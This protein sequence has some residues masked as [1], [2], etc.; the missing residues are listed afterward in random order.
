M[1]VVQNRD[2][3]CGERLN[4]AALEC[5]VSGMF[6][7][8]DVVNRPYL[9]AS[10]AMALAFGCS[11]VVP[12]DQV[13]LASSAQH[14]QRQSTDFLVTRLSRRLSS[15]ILLPL[16]CSLE[17]PTNNCSLCFSSPSSPSAT[18]SRI[19]ERPMKIE[20]IVDPARPLSLASRVAPA[21]A[22]PAVN[23]TQAPRLVSCV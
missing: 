6:G 2:W 18:T 4:R 22:A 15:Q 5:T 9:T 19:T 12:L 11:L 23:G 13:E 3:Y 21:A 10:S 16:V 1:A 8:E 7:G 14:R 20:I 17:Q